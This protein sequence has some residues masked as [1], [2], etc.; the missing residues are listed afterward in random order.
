MRTGRGPPLWQGASIK[1]DG[2]V[3]YPDFAAKGGKELASTRTWMS[4]AL[5]STSMDPESSLLVSMT[6]QDNSTDGSCLRP[7]KEDFKEARDELMRFTITHDQYL[8]QWWCEGFCKWLA[9]VKQK[10]WRLR[11]RK[12]SCTCFGEFPGSFHIALC[13]RCDAFLNW[14][15]VEEC[16]NLF[17]ALWTNIEVF[18][19]LSLQGVDTLFYEHDVS[20]I[21]SVWERALVV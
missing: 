11:N 7:R 10:I 21:P 15:L 9:N 18:V 1:A 13:K 5:G 2:A 6:T 17:W 20:F 12:S 16:P 3:L 4:I 19:C 14:L 8:G